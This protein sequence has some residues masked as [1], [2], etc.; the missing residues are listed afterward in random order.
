MWGSWLPLTTFIAISTRLRYL[1]GI[2]G[3]CMC[4]SHGWTCHSA[5]SRS[6]RSGEFAWNQHCGGERIFYVTCSLGLRIFRIEVHAM[7]SHFN[8]RF[9]TGV[10]MANRRYIVIAFS[11]GVRCMDQGVGY[12]GK[13]SFFSRLMH[14]AKGTSCIKAPL[15]RFMALCGQSPEARRL[16]VFGVSWDVG[17]T[18]W[19]SR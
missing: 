3:T 12:I 9:A 17:G 10:T 18:W 6:G 19:G 11:R 2:Y 7:C 8:P 4:P 14:A 5:D 16:D 1:A 15:F 13:G